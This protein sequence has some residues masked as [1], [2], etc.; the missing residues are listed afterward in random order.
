MFSWKNIILLLIP[1]LSSRTC[2]A[3]RGCVELDELTFDKVIKR[4]PYTLAKFDI[5]YP[6]GDKH[7][8]F[9]QFST[10]IAEN[11][12]ADLL[13]S[14]IGIKDYGEKENEALGKRFSVRTVFPDIKLFRNDSFATWT[15]YPEGREISVDNLKQFVREH[16]TLYIGLNGCI[17]E[18]DE[19]AGRFVKAPDAATIEASEKLI[20]GLTTEKV[21]FYFGSIKCKIFYMHFVL[22]RKKQRQ[23]SMC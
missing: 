3:C 1:L 6:Y 8:A 21:Y 13:V 15:N 4:F 7:E 20:E 10:E 19:I 12:V 23:K 2:F 14:V 16:T 9:S 11:N 22:C 18:F 17:R 5:A